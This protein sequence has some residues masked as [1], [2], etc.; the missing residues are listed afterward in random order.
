MIVLDYLAHKNWDRAYTD[1]EVKNLTEADFGREVMP[2]SLVW[3]IDSIDMSWHDEV[4]MID[5]AAALFYATDALSS[6]NPE[7]GFIVPELP[8][9]DY[10]DAN[11]ERLCHCP[12]GRCA[13]GRKVLAR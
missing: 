5:F 13:G 6:A 7:A 1:R 11:R 4:P 2:G 3:I 9:V 10:L 12:K 8:P